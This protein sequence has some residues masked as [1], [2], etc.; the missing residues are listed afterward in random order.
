MGNSERVFP[1]T[2]IC[3]KN[4]IKKKADL[5]FDFVVEK[6][7]TPADSKYFY[8]IDMDKLKSWISVST[9]NWTAP[10][11][12]RVIVEE[13]IY[14][15]SIRGRAGLRMRPDGQIARSYTSDLNT[16]GSWQL[17]KDTLFTLGSC[18]HID[19]WGADYT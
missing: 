13:A 16:M 7:A 10:I 11:N 6:N 3:I 12:S 18:F 17:D 8:A 19:I 1:C 4:K 5:H 15:S 14:S 2:G 9:L